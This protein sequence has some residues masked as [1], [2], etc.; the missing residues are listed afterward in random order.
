MNE[1]VK[2]NFGAI[3]IL[4]HQTKTFYQFYFSCDVAFF[5]IADVYHLALYGTA[6]WNDLFVLASIAF[7]EFLAAFYFCF[8]SC[9]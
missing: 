1:Q 5:E 7:P 2:L 9:T 6:G 3:L 4:F 8:A